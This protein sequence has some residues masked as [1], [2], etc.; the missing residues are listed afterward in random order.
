MSDEVD[1][2]L[3]RKRLIDE[4]SKDKFVETQRWLVD[5]VMLFRYIETLRG[6]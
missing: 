1:E 6:R 3:R 4:S 2:L 5:A